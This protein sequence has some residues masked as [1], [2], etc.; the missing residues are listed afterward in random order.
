MSKFNKSVSHVRKVIKYSEK[1]IVSKCY[2]VV[3]N[4]R[5]YQCEKY[6][7]EQ[8]KFQFKIPNHYSVEWECSHCGTA[9]KVT[10]DYSVGRIPKKRISQ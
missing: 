2:P 9:N 10:F 8:F 7:K 4:W 5:C 6:N 1:E 3:F